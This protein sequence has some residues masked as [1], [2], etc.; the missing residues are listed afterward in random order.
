MITQ[1]SVKLLGFSVKLAHAVRISPYQW[2]ERQRSLK[3]DT[4]KFHRALWRLISCLVAVNQ[5]IMLTRVSHCLFD[6]DIS[7]DYR[8]LA[9]SYL[10]KIGRA[11][12]RERV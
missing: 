3:K 9:V 2:N 7:S 4:S 5:V 12:C 11:S 8:I 1:L 10:I 6:P